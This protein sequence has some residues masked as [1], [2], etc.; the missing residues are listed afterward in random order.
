MAG[1]D[2]EAQIRLQC[3]NEAQGVQGHAAEE[4][5]VGPLQIHMDLKGA[6][7]FFLS[8]MALDTL[9]FVGTLETDLGLPVI[10][11]HQATLW[12][13]LRHCGVRTRQPELGKLFMI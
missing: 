5:H 2:R 12:S 13:A 7:V 10:T 11:S 1:D 6:D 8:C 4:E 9:S 3:A